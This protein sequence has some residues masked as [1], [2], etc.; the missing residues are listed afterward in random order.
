MFQAAKVK[1]QD[2]VSEAFSILYGIKQGVLLSTILFCV[3]IDD[4]TKELR[5]NRY[6]YWINA[7]FVGIHIFIYKKCRLSDRNI[8]TYCLVFYLSDNM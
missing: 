1:R 4:L 2:T 8:G 5:K 3:Y 6:G 7:E